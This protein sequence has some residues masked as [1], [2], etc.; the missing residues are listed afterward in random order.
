MKKRL[1]LTA[2]L[3]GSLLFFFGC[4]SSVTINIYVQDILDLV[5]GEEDLLMVDAVVRFESFGDLD[6]IIP[7]V[8]VGFPDAKNFREESRDMGTFVAA[9]IKVPLLMLDFHEHDFSEEMFVLE[10]EYY[11]EEYYIWLDFERSLYDDMSAAI[12]DEFWHEMT[13]SDLSLTLNISNDMRAPIYVEA[14]GVFMNGEPFPYPDYIMLER[15]DTA[16][17]KLSDVLLAYAYEYKE[18]LIAVLFTD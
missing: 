18:L 3:L 13:I 17:I 15:R 11:E 16:E 10:I 9:D 2:L 8:Q 7:V 5:E 4:T 12:Y 14:M 6:E 1:L